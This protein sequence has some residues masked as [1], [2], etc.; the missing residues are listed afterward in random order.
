VN[1]GECRGQGHSRGGEKFLT[2]RR[3]NRN[4][5]RDHAF[6]KHKKTL[7]CKLDKLDCKKHTWTFQIK[8]FSN[9]KNWIIQCGISKFCYLIK[10]LIDPTEIKGLCG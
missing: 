7:S 5:Y 4:A 10:T 6:N 3:L 1:R 2:G 9:N 8:V